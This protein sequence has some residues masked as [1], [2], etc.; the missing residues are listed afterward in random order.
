MNDML[1]PSL[2]TAFTVGLLS[3]LHCLSMCGSIMGALS[4]A[5]PSQTQQR[6]W[7]LSAYILI[8]NIGRIGSYIII[9]ALLGQVSETLIKQMFL[10]DGHQLL[11]VLTIVMMLMIG[12]YLGGWFSQLVQLEK[13]GKPI[14]RYLEPLG[15]RLM[16][17]DTLPKALAYG[18]VWGWMPCGI[19]YTMLLMAVTLGSAIDSAL[20]MLVFGLGTLP[21]LLASG[22]FTSRLYHFARNP[23]IRRWIG[24]LIVL[25]ALISLFFWFQH[26]QNQ[27]HATHHHTMH[28][29][30]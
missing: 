11:S 6:W 15:R 12:L 30:E 26:S 20:F 19:V 8:Y 16:P 4:F 22:L 27:E 7:Y 25:L 9:G 1:T 10:H 18:T 28:T 5:L 17:V 13:I 3:S 29:Q 23:T 2:L 24:S 14:W 21:T